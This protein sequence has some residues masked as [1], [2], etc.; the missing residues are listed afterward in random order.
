[1][2][3]DAMHCCKSRGAWRASTLSSAPERFSASPWLTKFSQR[4]VGSVTGGESKDEFLE[5]V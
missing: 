5:V 4:D 2:Q 1:M 3:L